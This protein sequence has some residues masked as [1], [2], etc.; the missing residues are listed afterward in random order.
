MNISEIAALAGVSR[1]AVSRYL[2][3][4]YVSQEKKEKIR[5]VIEETGYI[6]SAQAQ[7]LRTKKSRIIGV[8]IP[9]INSETISRIVEGISTEL[10]KEGYQTLL[11]NTSN[12]VSKELEYLELFKNNQVDGILFIATILS[13]RHEKIIKDLKIPVVVIGQQVHYTSCVYH[14]DFMA[15]KELT[16]LL[17]ED[18]RR[19]IAYMGVTRK[20]KAAGEARWEGFQAAVQQ[21]GIELAPEACI[22]VDFSIESGMEGAKKL[23]ETYPEVDGIFCATDSVAVGAI[24]YLKQAEKKIPEDVCVV[25]IGHTNF[26]NVVTPS[27]TCAHYYYKTSGIEAAGMLL[28]LLKNP[29]TAVKEVKLGYEIIKQG[30]TRNL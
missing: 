19:H 17:L 10:A 16:E 23:L 1:A 28:M 30:S 18:N 7:M 24:N 15:V 13:K 27:L 3:N 25:A 22:E 20:D 21:A 12:T 4:G 29:E 8:I 2:N 6:P 9:K 11:A 14:N 5:K 26:S